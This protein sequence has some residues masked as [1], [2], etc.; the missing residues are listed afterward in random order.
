MK[1]VCGFIAGLIHAPSK[2]L[3]VLVIAHLIQGIVLGSEAFQAGKLSDWGL[4][5]FL[6]I[7]VVVC[8]WRIYKAIQGITLVKEFE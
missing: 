2:L 6:T 4:L 8:T 5:S 1:E 7:V 3:L